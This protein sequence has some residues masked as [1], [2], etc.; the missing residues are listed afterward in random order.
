MTRRRIIVTA[1]IWAALSLELLRADAQPSILVLAAIVAL[2][3]VTLSIAVDLVVGIESVQWPALP[4][5]AP[6]DTSLQKRADKL[7]AHATGASKGSTTTLHLSLVELVDD[8]LLANHGIDRHADPER[9]D[10]VL[11]MSLRRLVAGP[12]RG[13][14]NAGTLSKL[15]RDIEEL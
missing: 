1:G 13:I 5:D 12:D 3:A 7:R 15:V 6:V 14:S 10:Q 11:P 4:S 9:A 2:I 8:R